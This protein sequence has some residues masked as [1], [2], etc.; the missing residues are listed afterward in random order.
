MASALPLDLLIDITSTGVKDAFTIGKLNTILI[1]KYDESLPNPKFNQVFDLS[2]TQTLFGSQSEV[3]GFAGVYFGI[4]SKSATKCDMLF[5]Y[6]WNKD[7]IPAVL[8]GGRAP[9]LSTLKTLNGKVKVTFGATSVDISIDLTQASSFSD[10]ASKIQT[11]I[12]GATG[13]ESNE[14]F[15]NASVAYSTV[16]NGFIVKGGQAG[17]GETLGYF[18]QADDGTDI[19]AK[20]GLT[21]DEGASLIEGAEGVATISDVLNEIDLYNGNFYVI[22]PNFEFDS[23]TFDEDLKAFGT[24]LNA[25]NDRFMGVYSWTNSQLEVLSSGVTE[26]YEGFNGLFI[27]NKKQD[28]QNAMV[29][30]LISAMDLTKPAGNYNIAFNDATQFQ[31]N[32][33][34]E[35]TK[36]LAMVGNKANAPCKFGILGQDDAVYM[37]GTIL[38]AKTDSVNVYICNSFLKFNQQIALYNM[39]KSQKLIGLRDKNSIA[40]IKSYLDEVFRNAVNANIIATGS[41]LTATE[42]NVVITNF[43][44][45]VKNVDDVI[46][47]IQENGYFYA[48]S[49][50]NTVTKELSITEAYMANAPVKKIVINTYILGA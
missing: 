49:G 46:K 3:A 25:S 32:A 14:N 23:G 19:H 36:Y 2:T 30:G 16:T 47:Q 31:V 24:F 11:A 50:V 39:F 21:A 33:I 1:Q 10:A 45:L 13:Q 40:I 20:F 35:K 43:K 38:G 29:C 26:P 44:A 48:V 8:K 28:Y 18:A 7:A 5:I 42:Q 17:Q 12:R 27:D 22:T 37:D 9:A 15:T 6:N 4:I 34:T 41:T